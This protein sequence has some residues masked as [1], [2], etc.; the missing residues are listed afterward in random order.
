VLEGKLQDFGLEAIFQLINSEKKTGTL[1][2]IRRAGDAEGFIYFRQGKIFGAVSNYNRQ[3]LGERLINAGHIT[4]EQLEQA[5]KVQKTSKRRRKLGQILISEG[6][7]TQETLQHFL[8]EQIQ[9]TVFDILPWTEGEFKFYDDKLPAAE[10]MGLLISARRLLAKATEHQ[11]EWEKIKQV[12]PSPQAVFAPKEG[13]TEKEWPT[14]LTPL[15][16]KIWQQLDGKKTLEE[17]ARALQITDYEATDHLY[18]LVQSGLVSLVTAGTKSETH[19]AAANEA[20][21]ELELATDDV[22]ADRTF[23]IN[24]L[25]SLTNA[26]ERSYKRHLFLAAGNK[27]VLAERVKFGLNLKEEQLQRLVRALQES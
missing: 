21:V 4:R 22:I 20:D 17:V 5:L 26:D 19:M 13:L 9:N 2:I 11:D 24:E 27:A 3:P 16:K 14:Q 6:L 25:I 15:H 1:H 10:D 7:I 23:F 12:V 8:R 18:D